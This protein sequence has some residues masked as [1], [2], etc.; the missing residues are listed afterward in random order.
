MSSLRNAADFLDLLRKR[1]PEVF[2][3]AT[4]ESDEEFDNAFMPFLDRAVRHLEEN[5]VL[6]ATLDEDGLSAAL[7]GELSIVGLLRVTQQRHSN[8]HVDITIER[9]HSTP[10]LRKLG[11]A[12]IY[13][14]IKRHVEGLTQLLKRYATGRDSG[15][16]IVY[17]QKK[18]IE[19]KMQLLRDEM[20]AQRPLAQQ[21]EAAN[22]VLHWSFRTAHKHDSGAM[23]RVD[24]IGCNLYTGQPARPA[25]QRTTPAKVTDG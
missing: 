19:S 12:K 9:E 24:H 8:G 7:V 11:E 5:K 17:C 23:V 16:L 25:A 4:A 2:D 13:D 10:A 6:F 21:G 18:N 3:L 22:H 20:D 14:G 15:L 1:A